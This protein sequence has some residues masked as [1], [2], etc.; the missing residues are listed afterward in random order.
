[1]TPVLYSFRRCP[2]A[3]RAR[4]ALD[5]SGVQVALREVVL[6]DKPQAFLEA[7]PS[8]TVPCLIDGTTVIDESID[9]MHWALQQNDPEGWLDMPQLGHDLIARFDGPFK[10]ALDRTKYATRYPDEDPE[11]HRRMASTF[12]MDLN[13]QIHGYIFGKPTLVDYAILPFVRQFAFIDKDWFDA[14]DWIVL[15]TWLDGFLASDRFNRIMP[16][17]AQWHPDDAPLMFP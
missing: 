16:K 6:R 17:F 8:G 12:L 1:M 10:S 4:L 5:V 9:I 13:A 3:M 11:E 14:Q 15:H 2:Y 7:S